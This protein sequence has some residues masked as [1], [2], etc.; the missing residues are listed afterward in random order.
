MP[1][2]DW[3]PPHGPESTRQTDTVDSKS[4]DSSIYKYKYQDD[5]SIDNDGRHGDDK[6]TEKWYGKEEHREID[7]RDN[8]LE[9]EDAD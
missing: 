3:S 1:R 6:Y 2:Q 5:H 9:E 8:K 4:R 7:E